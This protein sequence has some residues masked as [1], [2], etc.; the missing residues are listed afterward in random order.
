MRESWHS[1]VLI[2]QLIHYFFLDSLKVCRIECIQNALFIC[3]FILLS[4]IFLVVCRQ[5]YLFVAPVIRPGL[6]Y[7]A[8]VAR[9]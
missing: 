6:Q 5:R 8:A 4:L 7:P 3:L 9:T 2:A 1:G